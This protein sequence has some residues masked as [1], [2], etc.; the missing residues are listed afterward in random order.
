MIV[1]I[2]LDSS[3]SH[4]SWDAVIEAIHRTTPLMLVRRHG[5]VHAGTDT[6]DE[7]RQYV[8]QWSARAAMAPDRT[9]SLFC[10]LQAVPGRIDAHASADHVDC[11]VLLECP[12]LDID[13]V[14]LHR[15]R[16]FGC[17]TI[18]VL[19]T[20][21]ERHLRAQFG[22]SGVRIYRLLHTTSNTLPLYQPPDEICVSM[23]FDDAVS[24]PGMLLD[25]GNLLCHSAY[26]ALG[27]REA[28]R[29]D[30][31]V[32]DRSGVVDARRGR[33]MRAAITTL[34]QISVHVDALIRQLLGSLRRWWGIRVR[35]TSLK[36]AQSQ[37]VVLFQPRTSAQELL[38]NL[39][40][41]YGA[42][43]KDIEIINPWSVI[44]EDFA[45]IRGRQP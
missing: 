42:V 24:E 29:V 22:D 11:R 1:T 41:K 34:Q 36:A 8:R 20:L 17:S 12:E 45:R 15:L 35:L 31:G 18:G 7:I 40:P 30:V 9:S 10:A 13:E 39:V 37:Q 44:P 32:L 33:I 28:W 38:S 2:I 16:L 25:A 21:S 6:I 26:S 4:S 43:I 5:V 3:I 27:G 14:T 19:M 23:T